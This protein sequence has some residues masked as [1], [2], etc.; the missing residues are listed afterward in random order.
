M[1]PEDRAVLDEV[2]RK[3][4]ETIDLAE[5]DPATMIQI[6]LAQIESWV[7]SGT[8]QP[9]VAQWL[10]NLAVDPCVAASRVRDHHDGAIGTRCRRC[11]REVTW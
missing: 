7:E 9:D 2:E 11:G 1:K 4:N 5:G 8:M 3:V 6:L 10:T